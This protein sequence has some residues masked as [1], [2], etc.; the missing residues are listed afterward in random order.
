MNRFTETQKTLEN[1]DMLMN[2]LWRILD[3]LMKLESAS[4]ISQKFS[5]LLSDDLNSIT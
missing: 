1:L 2:S 3:E 4:T 5:R